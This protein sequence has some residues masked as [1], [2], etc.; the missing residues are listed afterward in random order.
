MRFKPGLARD[1]VTLLRPQPGADGIGGPETVFAPAGDRWGRKI[2]FQP[3]ELERED[4]RQG[5]A[6]VQL[7][8][9]LDSLTQQITTEWRLLF[10]GEQLQVNGVDRMREHGTVMISG[11]A[12]QE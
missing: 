6:D 3:T 9:R 2:R 1:K 5:R 7:L 12:P 4:Q 11:T 10:E 8:L